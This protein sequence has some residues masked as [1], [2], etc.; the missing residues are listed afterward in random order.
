MLQVDLQGGFG[1]KGRTSIVVGDGS[2]RVMLDAGIK[3]GA[4]GGEYYPLLAHPVSEI[5]ALFISHA[6]EDHIGAL[7]HLLRQGYA[8]PIYMTEET[9][10]EMPATLAQYADAADLADF[11]PLAK[12]IRLFRPGET[13][14]VGALNVATGASGHVVG[15]VWFSVEG[16]GQR[17]VYSADIVPESAVFPMQPL[18]ACDLLVLDASYGADPI[19]GAERA[20]QIGEWVA[21][22]ADGCLLPTPLSGRSLELIAAIGVPFAIEAGMRTALSAQILAPDA[23]HRDRVEVLS[24][25]LNV[26]HDWTVGEPLPACPLLVHDGMGVAGP[27]R[28]ALEA[29]ETAAFPILLSGHLPAGSPGARLVDEGK[30]AWIRMPTHPTLP[31]NIALWEA[32]GRPRLIGHSCD[33]AALDALRQHIPALM[34]GARTGDTY[35]INEETIHAHSDFQ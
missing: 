22:Y 35:Q 7:C 27:S 25:R 10:T 32:A 29:A 26:A 16:A 3:V 23:V 17:I 6:H 24:E 21:G 34:T 30:A 12:Q 20:R 19:P 2:T 28:P 15:G 9:H 4:T 13:L 33:A 18:P 1:E 14:A 31:E 11:P 8:G 5:D